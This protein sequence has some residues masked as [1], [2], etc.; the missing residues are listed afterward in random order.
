M[1]ADGAGL[2]TRASMH[3]DRKDSVVLKPGVT[4]HLALSW[5][6]VGDSRFTP[7][8]LSFTVPSDHKEATVRWG[9]GPVGA[10]RPARRGRAAA[11]TAEPTGA[12]ALG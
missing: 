11:L 1:R 7:R 10:R 4:A 12:V 2:P 5:T 8:L 9:A 6:V 3:G